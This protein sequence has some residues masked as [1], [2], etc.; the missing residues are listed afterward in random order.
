MARSP[1]TINAPS[2]TTSTPIQPSTP[3]AIPGA[4]PSAHTPTT[5]TSARVRQ[6]S[7]LATSSLP[8][9]ITPAPAHHA[10]STIGTPAEA[11][12]S[13]LPK[14]HVESKAHALRSVLG[15]KERTPCPYPSQYGGKEKCGVADDDERDEVLMAICAACAVMVGPLPRRSGYSRSEMLTCM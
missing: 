6:P 10:S 12:S 13:K 11:S 7:A 4:N 8:P 9:P 14:T 15:D 2:P 3:V 5:R 1:R